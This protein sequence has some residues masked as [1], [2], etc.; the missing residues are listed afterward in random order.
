MALF[1]LDVGKCTGCG[2]CQLVCSAVKAKVFNPGIACMRTH[3]YY[4]KDGLI[5][6]G[7]FCDLC[8]KCV[9][10]CP[11]EAI[12]FKNGL[13]RIDQESCTKCELCVETCPY[14]VIHIAPSGTLLLCDQCGGSPEC[15]KWCPHEA[16][17]KQED[18][19]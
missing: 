5:I 7:E 1:K 3:S 17:Y 4:G 12:T 2:I 19:S 15:M 16:I 6:K 14:G 10:A 11:P 18:V 13:L 8:L 9:E